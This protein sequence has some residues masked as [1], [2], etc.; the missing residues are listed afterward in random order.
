MHHAKQ[1]C[2]ELK[3]FYS[4]KSA[5]YRHVL[6]MEADT[7]VFILVRCALEE[8]YARKLLQ[9]SRKPLGS[10]ERG[11]LKSSMDTMRGE[12]ESMGKAHQSVA[13]Q[14]KVELEEPL[15]AFAGAMKERRKIVQNGIE[16]L[17]KTKIEQ[18]RQVHK[19]RAY[20]RH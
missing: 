14:M 5:L 7:N 16:K 13:Q 19:V 4:G 20:F 10:Q 17:L 6:P 8:E 15:A 12:I 18:T 3:A 1:T 2:D 11:T 9:L